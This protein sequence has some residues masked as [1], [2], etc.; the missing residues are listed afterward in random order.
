[1]SLLETSEALQERANTLLRNTGL[2]E[3]LSHF[4]EVHF[5]GAYAGNVM[6]HGDIDISVVRSEPFTIDEIFEIFRKLYF[7]GKFR[8]YFISGDWDD[9]RKGDEFPKGYY[10]GLKEKLNGER[11]KIDIW[12][13]GEEE[14][15]RRD[16]EFQIN[17][18]TLTTK[19]KENILRLKKERNEQHLS[20][21]GQTIYR[22]VIEKGVST[23]D[24]VIRDSKNTLPE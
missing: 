19:Q 11:W 12:F 7:E 14:Y 20:I 13:V 18:I 21:S 17:K 23:L 16:G 22:S 2:E 8:S 10:I 3:F 24:E 15:K 5:T 6:M 9:P 4:G 1:M